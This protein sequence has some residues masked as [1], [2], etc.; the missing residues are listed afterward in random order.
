MIKRCIIITALVDC[1]LS[2]IYKKQEGD[3]IICADGGIDV[4]EENDI[5]PDI[6]L[7]DLDSTD[8]VDK[9]YKFKRF[10]KEK[11]DTDTCLCLKYGLS[12]G[13]RDFIIIG[14]I[15][16]RLDHTYA[17]IQTLSY[18]LAQGADARILSKDSVCRMLGAGKEYIIPNKEGFYISLFSYSEKCEGITIK[19]TK[20]CLENA[21]IANSFPLGVS[22][23]FEGDTAFIHIEK[24]TLLLILSRKN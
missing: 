19:G 12:L 16:G 1:A 15:G 4:A 17:N 14:G 20:Y 7:G 6:V 10:P 22:N 18:A 9:K 11:D 2:E 21:S 23:E 24:G 13:Y 5:I 8:C 3:Y